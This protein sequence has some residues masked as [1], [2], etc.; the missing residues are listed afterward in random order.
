MK[1]FKR[2][3]AKPK[4]DGNQPEVVS[5]GGE[6]NV[7]DYF[8]GLFPS[9]GHSSPAKDFL[10]PGKNFSSMLFRSVIPDARLGNSILRLHNRHEKFEDKRHDQ[11]LED[12]LAELVARN[13]RARL[14]AL[15][16][17]TNMLSPDMYNHVAGFI[18]G[19]NGKQM[20]VYS[21]PKNANLPRQQVVEEED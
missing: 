17:T 6:F 15:F 7:S 12:K 11:M 19:K 5:G 13:G 16:G 8:E 14:E 1:I 3:R 20:K 10:E 9:V 4:S 2:K 21:N 18:L